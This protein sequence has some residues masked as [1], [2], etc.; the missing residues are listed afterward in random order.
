AAA[1]RLADRPEHA[2]PRRL[3]GDAAGARAQAARGRDADGDDRPPHPRRGE[4]GPRR[5]RGGLPRQAGRPAAGARAVPGADRDGREE[6]AAEVAANDSYVS[7]TFTVALSA[8][9]PKGS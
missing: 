7:A 4:E 3:R 6:V 9:R 1:A 5:R 8:A 2:R